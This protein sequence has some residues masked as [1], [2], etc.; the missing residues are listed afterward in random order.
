MYCGF[1]LGHLYLAWA[2][3]PV[4]LP[5]S[6]QLRQANGD[7]HR[8]GQQGLRSHCRRP[9]HDPH[10]TSC[11]YHGGM[12]LTRHYMGSPSE[13]F[14]LTRN[15][16]FSQ[17]TKPHVD[18]CIMAQVPLSTS[19]CLH[20][21]CCTLQRHPPHVHQHIL[22]YNTQGSQMHSLSQQPCRSHIL[23]LRQT[24]LQCP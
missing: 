14:H 8:S 3:Q 22:P 5:G 23:P 18:S 20:R 13:K 15:Q 19:V 1:H 9:P 10:N 24:Q 7:D 12:H 16:N 17:E 2:I 4:M 6:H 11:I 21:I